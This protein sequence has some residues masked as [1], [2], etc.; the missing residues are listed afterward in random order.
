MHFLVYVG[1]A[2]MAGLIMINRSKY[3]LNMYLTIAAY[4]ASAL[5][6]IGGMVLSRTGGA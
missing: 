3:K 4:I 5:T 2:M 6:I 1:I